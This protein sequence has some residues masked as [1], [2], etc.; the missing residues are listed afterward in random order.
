MSL[1]RMVPV[2]SVSL[3]LALVG[4]TGDELVDG[5]GGCSAKIGRYCFRRHY[6]L[7]G[8]N[9]PPSSTKN[10]HWI[11]E[12]ICIG[13]DLSV[14]FVGW[15][16][17]RSIVVLLPAL[18]LLSHAASAKDSSRWRQHVASSYNTVR[19]GMRRCFPFHCRCC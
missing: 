8:G 11:R 5:L 14:S 6:H 17:C 4:A 2:S 15:S 7:S 18:L 9:R 1:R 12:G 19:E 13:T 10:P 16:Q 3:V